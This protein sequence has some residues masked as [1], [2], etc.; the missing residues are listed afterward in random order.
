VGLRESI[1]GKNPAMESKIIN[2]IKYIIKLRY[3][4][5]HINVVSTQT[6][7]QTGDAN[8]WYSVPMQTEIL[9]IIRLV[10]KTTRK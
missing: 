7:S 8:D 4:I 9:I 10:F 5:S 6:T 2:T 1:K 3:R